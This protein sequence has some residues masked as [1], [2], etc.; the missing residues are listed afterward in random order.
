MCDNDVISELNVE[1]CKNAGK[2][3]GLLDIGFAWQGAAAWMVVDEHDAPDVH[4]ERVMD[5]QSNWQ[6]DPK[7]RLFSR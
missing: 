1:R 3:T 6:F 7:R 2:M 4:G 5:N